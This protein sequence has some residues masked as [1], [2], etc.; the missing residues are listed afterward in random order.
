MAYQIKLINPLKQF[1][2][3]NYSLTFHDTDGVVP[4][5]RWE[6]KYPDT[7]T[8]Q[9]AGADIKA[10]IKAWAIDQGL[11]LADAQLNGVEFSIDVKGG[12]K[13]FEF[14]LI[15]FDQMF[16][17]KEAGLERKLKFLEKQNNIIDDV[18]YDES[19]LP[20]KFTN[21][22]ISPEDVAFYFDLLVDNEIDVNIIKPVEKTIESQVK[23]TYTSNFVVS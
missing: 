22:D 4:D 18:I 11:T 2:K 3:F 1:G 8:K 19:E 12:T 9:Q 16:G 17:G 7:V 10:T 6:K 20:T 14:E 23:G 13:N 21:V 5:M 15:T